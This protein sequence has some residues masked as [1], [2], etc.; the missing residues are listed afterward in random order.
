MDFNA[1][2]DHRRYAPKTALTYRRYALRAARF[3]REGSG[4]ELHDADLEELSAFRA[5][6]PESS[7]SQSQARKALVAYFEW[8]RSQRLVD[9]NLALELDSFPRP[10]RLPRPLPGGG[11]ERFIATS[12]SAGGELE[13]L[14]LLFAWTGCR[15]SEGQRAAWADFDLGENPVWYIVGKGSGRRGPRTRQMPL[16]DELAALL[17]RHRRRLGPER[18]VFP[19]DDRPG[20][21][22]AEHYLRDAFAELFS[23][24]D[25]D[26]ATPHRLR[27]TFATV[28]L[29]QGVDLRVLQ[30]LLGHASI[31]TT[32]L[33]TF[34][35]AGRKRAGVELL[36]AG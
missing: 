30:E 35:V 19:R 29:E 7:E 33:Y 20:E 2:L 21:S 12:R 25:L 3:V 22:A 18:F 15:F 26:G 17:R 24:A 1:W 36:P 6:L 5:L 16:R 9:V 32:E 14:G 13:V 11:L 23:G 4:G 8:A 28:L 31:A 27:H 34:V 10:Y